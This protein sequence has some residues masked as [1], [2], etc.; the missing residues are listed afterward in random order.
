VV[1]GARVT[2]GLVLL[3]PLEGAEVGVGS[4]PQ[5]T[6]SVSRLKRAIK[7]KAVDL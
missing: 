6:S 4:P 2:A 1:V 3:L 7:R 5:A